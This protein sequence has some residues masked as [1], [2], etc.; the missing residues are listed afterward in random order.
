M[1]PSSRLLYYD[2]GMMAD[3]DGIVEAFTVMR[4][5]GAAE[6]DLKVL[7]SKGFVSILNEDLVS[8]ITDWSRNNQIRRDRYQPSVYKDLLVKI[9]VVDQWLPNGLPD[10]NQRLTQYSIGK[11]SVVKE[12]KVESMAPPSAAP[13]PT[14]KSSEKEPKK[15][16][17]Q[18]GWIKLTETEYSRLLE[19]LGQAELGRCI[20]YI[21]ESA[22]SNGNKNKWRDWNLV[23]RRCSR[24]GWG[25]NNTER[26]RL[27]TA[28]DYETGG[29]F[30]G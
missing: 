5:T 2:L 14:S 6:D 22:Q 12:S 8:L 3:D 20:K 9:D 16:Y 21:D 17:G 7:V 23:L 13:A 1:P 28:A 25:M 26:D 30:F 24:E 15:K 4:T 11:D 18:Y 10:G 19:D 27:R 29:D